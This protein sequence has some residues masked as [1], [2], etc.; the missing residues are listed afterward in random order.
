MYQVILTLT[1]ITDI[2]SLLSPSLLFEC[3]VQL[4]F[5]SFKSHNYGHGFLDCIFGNRKYKTLHYEMSDFKLQLFNPKLEQN[6]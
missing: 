1:Q 5:P 2:F 3:E 4:A 6:L